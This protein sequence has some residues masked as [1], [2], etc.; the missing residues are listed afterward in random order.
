M[1][2]RQITPLTRV[3]KPLQLTP[4]EAQRRQEKDERNKEISRKSQATME[5]NKRARLNGD[6]QTLNPSP[7]L[8]THLPGP[9]GNAS[10]DIALTANT[11]HTDSPSAPGPTLRGGGTV[12]EDSESDEEM[13]V[14]NMGSI[15][16]Y[17]DD[18]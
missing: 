18:E 2:R 5:L 1:R 4:E 12:P 9:D 14:L 15:G 16:G 7:E 17:E 3:L 10:S 6:V 8:S 13:P 11:S